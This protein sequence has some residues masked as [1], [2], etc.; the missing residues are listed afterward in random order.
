MPDSSIC[1]TITGPDQTTVAQRFSQ[2]LQSRLDL[3]QIPITPLKQNRNQLHGTPDSPKKDFIGAANL[4]VTV[5]TLMLTIPSAVLACRD[6]SQRAANKPKADDLIE[7]A[8][9][10]HSEFPDTEITLDLKNQKLFLKNASAAELLDLES[11]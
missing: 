2:I 7:A 4:A 10:L 9:Q 1:F 3:A 5:T 6:L 11:K 8:R